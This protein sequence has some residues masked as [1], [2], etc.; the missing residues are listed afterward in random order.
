[1]AETLAGEAHGRRVDQW[2]DL[3]DVVADHAEEQ[4][5]VAVVQGGER[6]E[7]FERIGQA[8]QVGEEAR[9]LLV[10]GVDVRRQQAAQAQRIALDLGEGGALVAQGIVQQR[11]AARNAVFLGAHGSP[12]ID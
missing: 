11:Y 6:N 10:L 8:A 7:L 9:H 4:R 2:H 5:L 1:M 12:P 3:V